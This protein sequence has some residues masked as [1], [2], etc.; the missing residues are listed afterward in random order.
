MTPKEGIILIMYLV[1]FKSSFLSICP[2]SYND[3]K[4]RRFFS[5]LLSI[6][7]SSVAHGNP[8]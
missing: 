4:R 6:R 3:I 1:L 7:R 5:N 2:I 8:K